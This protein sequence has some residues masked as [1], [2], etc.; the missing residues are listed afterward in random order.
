MLNYV[1]ISLV[2]IGILA[3]A[4]N[5]IRDEFTNPYRNSIPL[6]GIIQMDGSPASGM[7]NIE[8]ELRIPAG[9]FAAFYGLAEG[10]E[11]R[12][13]VRIV[14]RD[15]GSSVITIPVGET[16][17]AFWRGMARYGANKDRLTGIVRGISISESRATITFVL[18]PVR[19]VKLRAVTQGAFDAAAG[20]VAIA[21]G[22]IG[23]M[24]LWLG[25]MKVAEE[26][27]AVRVVTKL[28]TPLT[29]RLFPEVPPDHPAVGAMIMNVSANMLGLSNAATPFGLKAMEEL[30]KLNPKIGTATNAMCT[31]L[32]INTAGL[33]IIP[34]T[35]IA[36][37]AAAG[38]VNPG[39]IIGTSIFGAGCATVAGLIAVKL[40]QRL[41]RFRK[42]DPGL[43]EKE[44]ARG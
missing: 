15:D 13:S 41:P 6:E 7:K 26:S 32:T 18:D 42:D 37:R 24:A 2:V 28:L 23:I 21:F 8:G 9:A 12:Q 10:Q 5:D 22:L 1:W 36:V 3:A 40:L 19:F 31:F 30:N 11:V 17:P 16:T 38:S 27:G 29:Q 34:A 43:G 33:V 35:A 14:P 39:I 20:A 44:V 4:G 25:V